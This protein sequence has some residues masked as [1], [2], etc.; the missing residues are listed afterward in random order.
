M[1]TRD[2]LEALSFSQKME[3][4]ESFLQDGV[5]PTEFEWLQNSIYQ[6]CLSNRIEWELS[7]HEAMD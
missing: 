1:N 3:L 5:E 2:L 6:D 4:W 7:L